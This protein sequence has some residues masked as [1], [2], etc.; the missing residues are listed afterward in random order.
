VEPSTEPDP[1][2]TDVHRWWH[3]SG[4]SPELVG[5]VADGFVSRATRVLD[6]GCGLGS[7]LGWLHETQQAT[8]AVGV[9]RSA[10]ALE[11]M[12]LL[13]PGV[14][15]VRA[16]VTGLPF[17]DGRFDVVIDRGCFHY[18]SPPGRRRYGIEAAR[19]LTPVGRLFLRASLFSAGRRNDV[20]EAGVRSALEG[21][22]ILAM[23]ETDL[24][25]DTR[26][27]HALIVRARR[28]PG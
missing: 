22:E 13:H 10:A 18:L 7:E 14:H 8:L 3:L 27:L 19:V 20:D 21:W 16:D 9:D 6:T 12:A 4:P 5:A 25:S 23:E 1:Y 26:Q 2:E 28:P 15:G 24:R 17:P 11:R